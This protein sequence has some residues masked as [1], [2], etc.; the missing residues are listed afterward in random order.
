MDGNKL[1]LAVIETVGV[2]APPYLLYL[3]HATPVLSFFSAV[4]GVI[5]ICIKAI[6]EVR[7]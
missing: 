3:E 2:S 4:V 5:Y 1:F 6:R 7:K